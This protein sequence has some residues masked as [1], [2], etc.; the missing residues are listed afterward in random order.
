MNHDPRANLAVTLAGEL[1]LV[2]L[3]HPSER[4]AIDRL[5]LVLLSMPDLSG[6]VAVWRHPLSQELFWCRL[7]DQ[8]K[9]EVSDHIDSRA[10][11]A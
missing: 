8:D 7:E 11:Q 6:A 10:S 3:D 9:L 1:V 2:H 4:E 5:R